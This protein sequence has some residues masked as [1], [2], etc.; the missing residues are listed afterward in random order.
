[1][2]GGV[3]TALTN[4]GNAS[5]AANV[6]TLKVAATTNLTQVKLGDL[7]SV[8]SGVGNDAL[9]V[10]LNV[11]GLIQGSAQ[12]ANKGHFLSL[13][14]PT[15]G[16]PGVATASLQATVVEPPQVAIGPARQS[17]GQ[18]VTKTKTA[19][20]RVLLKVS[21]LG[22][23]VLLPIYI[24]AGSATGELTSITCA[25]PITNSQV[26]VKV[27]RSAAE[28]YVGNVTQADMTD[29]ASGVTVSPA[30]LISVILLGQIN[31]Y[32]HATVAAGTDNLTFTGQAFNWTAPAKTV[33]SS[34]L[35]LGSLLSSLQ[36]SNG[37]GLLGV[38]GGL[39]GLV[40]SP[41]LAAVGA[42][43][44]VVDALLD[45][46]LGALGIMVGGADVWAWHLECGGR[47]LVR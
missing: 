30:P 32:A 20:L 11:L 15:L 41:V 47:T 29:I 46:L 45:P 12:V 7:V 22:G 25:T 2:L 31:M 6:H 24:E 27:T 13:N 23:T 43:L 17:G 26:G 37:G 21:I 19:Q 38:V 14:I 10:G 44:G 4:Q 1:M 40:L 42:V 3:E 18:W 33:G 5:L 28:L 8:A 36:L 39:A 34:S 35:G 16:V 9:D